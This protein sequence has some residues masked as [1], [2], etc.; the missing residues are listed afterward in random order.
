MSFFNTSL[1]HA[2]M[3]EQW[4]LCTVEDIPDELWTDQPGGLTNHPAWVLGHLVV[5]F[6]NVTKQLGVTVPR[7]DEWRKPFDGGSKP[8]ANR[9]D[10]PSKDELI[11][12]F[13][14]SA[15]SLRR[16]LA[17]A[18]ESALEKPVEDEQIAPFFPTLGRWAVHCLLSEGAFHTGQL[19]AWRRAKGMPAVFEV[20]ANGPRLMANALT[21]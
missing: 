1:E 6:D 5:A 2:A 17:G 7:D 8:S 14:D 18:G 10:Y 9:G 13:K 3:L 20:E 21:V 16:A 19:S 11:A 4:T 12:T 15:Q